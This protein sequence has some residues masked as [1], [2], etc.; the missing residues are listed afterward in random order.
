M[1]PRCGGKLFREHDDVYCLMCGFREP[2]GE[3]WEPFSTER[4]H[5]PP[6]PGPSGESFR[7]LFTEREKEHARRKSRPSR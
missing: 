2:K 5:W 7:L 3:T 1:C 6:G 4:R